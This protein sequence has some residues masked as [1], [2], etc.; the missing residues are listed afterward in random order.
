MNI[1][2]SFFL[3]YLFFYESD[4]FFNNIYYRTFSNNNG[5]I[6]LI[7]DFYNDHIYESIK[8]IS[9]TNKKY[10]FKSNNYFT[11]RS[12]ILYDN[13]NRDSLVILK[14]LTINSIHLDKIKNSI[15]LNM[16]FIN[17]T[18]ILSLEYYDDN[19]GEKYH[20]DT[21]LIHGKR[22]IGIYSIFNNNCFYYENNKIKKKNLYIQKNRLLLYEG[23]KIKHKVFCK[24]S[25]SFLIFKFCTSCKYTMNP[26]YL[27]SNRITNSYI[28]KREFIK[29]YL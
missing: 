19:S 7:D 5:E 3:L 12:F 18:S 22:W 24:N 9:I 4:I 25:S 27:L 17:D 8:E 26:Y 21:I 23:H 6:L 11:N 1:I 16:K 2:Y 13:M 14:K 29:G 28:D 10:S 15:N 20:Y